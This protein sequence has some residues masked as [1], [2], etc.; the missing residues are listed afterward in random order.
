MWRR[1]V[2]NASARRHPRVPVDMSKTRLAFAVITFAAAA[3]S[4][5]SAEGVLQV[6]PHVRRPEGPPPISLELRD[7]R[8]LSPPERRIV[9][10]SYII[11]LHGESLLAESRETR[12]SRHASAH[13]LLDRLEADLVALSGATK[14]GAAVEIGHRYTMTMAGAEARLPASLIDDV[15]KL[16]YVRSVTPNRIFNALLG[17]SVRQIGADVVWQEMGTRGSG[18]VVAVID[19]GVAYHH[20]ALGGGFGPGFKVGGGHDFVNRDPDPYDDHGHGTHVAGIIAADGAVR[21]V[22]PDATL[23]AYKVLG[24]DGSGLESDIIAAVERSVDPNGDGDS[25]DAVHVVNMSLGSFNVGDDPLVRAV[26]TATSAGVLFCV[27]AGNSG[28][29][30]S[31][32]SPGTSPSALTVGAV[33][34]ADALAS[35]SSIGPSPGFFGIKPEV[36]APGVAI[37]SLSPSGIAPQSGTSMAAPHVAGVA[38]LVRALHP[39]WSAD[40]VKSAIV[41]TAKDLGLSAMHQGGGRVDALAAA[42]TTL[43]PGRSTIE[44]G[45]VDLNASDWSVTRQV[46]VL[47]RGEST[48]ALSVTSGPAIDEVSINIEPAQLSVDPGKVGV[49]TVTATISRDHPPRLIGESVAVSGA[50]R[51]ASPEASL[52]VPWSL[53]YAAPVAVTLDGMDTFAIV[54]NRDRVIPVFQ[55]RLVPYG[56]YD[57]V[58][59]ELTNPV[60][61]PVIILRRGVEIRHQTT[62]AFESTEATHTLEFSATDEH[63]LGLHVR[64]R[65]PAGVYYTGFRVQYPPDSAIASLRNWSYSTR[66]RLSNLPT[67]FRVFGTNTY[68]DLTNDTVYAI[69]HTGTTG[70]DGSRHFTLGRHDLV[71]ATVEVHR[72][73]EGIAWTILAESR[74]VPGGELSVVA[75]EAR[76][77]DADSASWTPRAFLTKASG[78]DHA[79]GPLFLTS[80]TR[81]LIKMQTPILR[82]SE[83]GVSTFTGRAPSP[84][85]VFVSPSEAVVAGSLPVHLRANLTFD[86]TRAVLEGALHGTADE[87]WASDSREMSCTVELPNGQVL[88]CL[89]SPLVTAARFSIHLPIPGRYVVRTRT[90][91]LTQLDTI[92]TLVNE[93]D[94]EGADST[95]PTLTSLALLQEGQTV[96]ST[97]TFASPLVLRFSAADFNGTG[98][99]TYQAVD[100]GTA[101]VYVR[102]HGAESWALVPVVAIDEENGDADIGRDPI[103][104]LFEADLSAATRIPGSVDLRLSIEDAAGNR[105]DWVL[106]PALEITGGRRHPL[107][108]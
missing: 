108:R 14:T 70:V 32:T 74:H 42:S 82:A 8:V 105:T 53:L 6:P 94:P 36:V 88:P 63:G 69:E 22:A 28:M 34:R 85:S 52:R 50:L 103:G 51:I 15:K 73:G 4:M 71:E 39:A 99:R 91:R 62:L 38:A 41:A 47:N 76:P 101:R 100:T 45:F 27:S 49:V 68:F 2:E 29:V 96:R 13:A 10:D 93:F 89:P 102:R 54:S 48:V 31:I 44:F 81:G 12:A 59:S 16:P 3:A 79:F 40:E 66:V 43:L 75:L 18:V 58:I 9:P 57:T 46:E 25:S 23:H 84:A 80:D 60:E 90:P 26:E 104:V 92:G 97:T 33:D 72:P 30:E 19:T 64:P 107:R 61:P 95:P 86:G 17:V 11:S 67:D 55:S 1:H 35:F 5:Q 7:G 78:P 56:V 106:E 21:G 37:N 24:A 20:P 83:R 98:N 77:L 65:R 87:R